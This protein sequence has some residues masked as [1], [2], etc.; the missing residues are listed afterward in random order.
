M[1][2]PNEPRRDQEAVIADI[3]QA[4]QKAGFKARVMRTPNDP[5][6]AVVGYLTPGAG[7]RRQVIAALEDNGHCRGLLS[8]P[9][10]GEDNDNVVE[11]EKAEGFNTWT[12]VVGVGDTLVTSALAH[13]TLAQAADPDAN[14][15]EVRQAMEWIADPVRNAGSVGNP[16]GPHLASLANA[17]LRLIERVERLERERA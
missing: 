9:Y 10:Q 13:A 2:P 4:F 15:D 11:P 14:F 17:M 16:R 5:F 3:E 8:Q 12:A 7:K 6:T 1:A